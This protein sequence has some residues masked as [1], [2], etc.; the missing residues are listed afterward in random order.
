MYLKNFIVTFDIKA[1]ENTG[2]AQLFSLFFFPWGFCIDTVTYP[3]KDEHYFKTILC[4][5]PKQG[6]IILKH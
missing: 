1:H 3:R 2:T 5:L 6:E 4:F